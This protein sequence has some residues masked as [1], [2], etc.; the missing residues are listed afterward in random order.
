M[1][2][3][4]THGRHTPAH[5]ALDA[6][7]RIKAGFR[8][9]GDVLADGE[10]VSYDV[11]MMDAAPAGAITMH[12]EGTRPFVSPAAQRQA[13]I[14]ADAARTTEAR[15][16]INDQLVR[17]SMSATIAE[18]ATGNSLARDAV[19]AIRDARTAPMAGFPA[20]VDSARI[21]TA[22][23]SATVA[24]IRAARYL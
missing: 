10:R 5:I 3:L 18:R 7:G 20:P 2:Y 17:E 6:S 1:A 13:E 12:D 15:R 19:T 4:D 23:N 22:D 11:T 14:T 21:S 24:A 16:I 8:A 9:V